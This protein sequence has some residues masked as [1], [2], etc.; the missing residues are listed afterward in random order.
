MINRTQ[1]HICLMIATTLFCM[2]D[3]LFARGPRGGGGFRGGGGY[4]GG[5]AMRSAPS[6]APSYNRSPSMSRNYSRPTTPS[7]SNYSRTNTSRSSVS[8]STTNRASSA[9]QTRRSASSARSSNLQSSRAYQRPTQN[10]VGDFLN[11]PKSSVSSSNQQSRS[12]SRTYETRRGGTVTVGGAGGKGTTAGGVDVGGGVSGVKIETA[13]GNTFVRGRGGV[14]ATDGTNSAVR[15]GSFRG[16][17]DRYG[18]ARGS[19]R[20]G[21]IVSDGTNTRGR[22][23]AVAGARDAYGNAVVRGRGIHTVNGYVVGRS[24]VVAVRRGFRG[25]GWYYSPGWYARYPGAWAAVGIATTAWW[26]GSTWDVVYPYAG[27]SENLYNYNYGD[28]VT[29]EG[30]TVYYGEKAAATAEQYYEQA[31][32]IADEGEETDNEEWLPLG[33]FAVLQEG[34]TESDKVVQLAINKEGVIRGNLHDKLTDKVTPLTGSADKRTQRVAIR[35]VGDS[36]VVV[37]AGLWNLTQDTLT[38]LIHLDANQTETRSLVRLS[39]PENSSTP[40]IE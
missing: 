23:G 20:G 8:R 18:N 22:F 10:Q 24:Q 19:A 3:P 28:N 15:G 27:T 40:P 13:G 25:Y 29:Y 31:E 39:Q 14:G 26:V 34:Q 4:R 17:E 37:E 7:R 30:D 2:L 33:V 36:T 11:L 5:G 21:T 6:R 35:P 32:K 1:F 12:G 38:V 9:S 16:A